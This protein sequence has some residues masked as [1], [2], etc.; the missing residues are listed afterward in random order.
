MIRLEVK[1]KVTT[2]TIAVKDFN[3]KSEIG[4]WLKQYAHLQTVYILMASSSG[5]T[6]LLTASNHDARAD[7]SEGGCRE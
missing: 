6:T 3:S 2:G 5:V 4:P 7:D 1:D